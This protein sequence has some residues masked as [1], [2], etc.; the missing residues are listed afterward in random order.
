MCSLRRRPR[1]DCDV[2]FPTTS[3][4]CASWPSAPWSVVI[5]AS[6]GGAINIPVLT[7]KDEIGH[8]QQN[9]L[10]TLTLQHAIAKDQTSQVNVTFTNGNN[11]HFLIAASAVPIQNWISQAKPKMS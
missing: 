8:F 7:A 1:S 3:A 10:V 4:K 5:I 2:E 9:G 11:P 6:A